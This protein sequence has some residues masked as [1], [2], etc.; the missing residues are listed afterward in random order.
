LTR[1]H[2]T[3]IHIVI[4]TMPAVKNLNKIGRHFLNNDLSLFP[5]TFFLNKV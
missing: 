1:D 4:E 2:S 5:A 3:I